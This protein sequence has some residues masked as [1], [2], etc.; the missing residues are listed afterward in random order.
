MA[1]AGCSSAVL[2]LLSR[3]EQKGC[4]WGCLGCDE[5]VKVEL[6]VCCTGS[7]TGC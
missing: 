1:G 4:V 5:G 7:S 3:S 2:L 6:I